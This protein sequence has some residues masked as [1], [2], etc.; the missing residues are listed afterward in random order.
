MNLQSEIKNGRT[1]VGDIIAY[2][3]QHIVTVTGETDFI[4]V[5]YFKNSVVPVPLSNGTEVEEPREET[6]NAMIEYS[7]HTFRCQILE[8]E[9]AQQLWEIFWNIFNQLK[10]SI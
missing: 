8:Q 3:E 5:V 7:S 9:S 4:R 10:H 6:M 2:Y 1:Q